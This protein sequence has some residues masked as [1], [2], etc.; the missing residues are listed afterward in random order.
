MCGICGVMRL[1]GDGAV[2]HDLVERMAG[3]MAHRGP[4]DAGAYV[5]PDCRVGMGHRRLSIVDLSAAG[6]GP[7]SNED[8]TVW[9]SYN[10]EVYN[11]EEWRGPLER[12]GH[13]YR[14]RTDTETL[15]H[16][17]EDRGPALVEALRGIFAFSL[18]DERR[19]RLVL[20]R[21]RLGVKPLYYAAVDGWLVWG[22]EIKALLAHPAVTAELDE[23]ALL[24]YLTFAAVPPP[25]TLFRGIRKLAPG[26]R[27]V[28][29]RG[30][31]IRVERWWA[32]AGHP[33]PD[34]L[35]DAGESEIVEHLR[36]L[37]V[38]AVREETMAD[39]PHGV[40]LSGGVD[41]SLVL[42]ILAEH[43]PDPVETFSV[44][45]EGQ[46]H[47]DERAHARHAAEQFGSHHHELVL[48]PERVR[49]L[50]PELVFG[51]DEP[52][53]DWVCLPLMLL[54]R[55]VKESGVTV[56]QVG[57]GSD[58]LFSGYPRYRRY[59]GLHHGLWGRYL[60]APAAL[61]RVGG[62]VA[63]L[64][65][66]PFPRLREPRDLFRRAA[67]G[68]PLFVSGAVANWYADKRR[69]LAPR[70][71]ERLDGPGSSERVAAANIAEFHRLSGSDDVAAAIA[72]QDLMV[73]LPEL[74]L[75]RVDKMTMLNSVEARVPFLDHRIVEL[76]MGLPW[77]LKLRNGT[78]KHVLK[79]AARAYLGPEIVD[80][81][82]KGFDVPLSAWLRDD[83]FGRWA[84]AAVLESRIARADVFDR[85]E[86]IRL[87]ARHRAGAGDHGFQLWTLVNLCA[88]YDHWVEPR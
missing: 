10:G 69:Q 66:A 60:R 41:S 86:L 88:W 18:W 16:L 38:G 45:F 67:S 12:A 42:A 40:L 27:L 32:P 1:G 36:T 11:H 23:D 19:E 39:V 83:A 87:F 58:E 24:Q 35:D 22:S 44:G 7:M 20:A 43:L 28:V 76:A 64:A 46:D 63:N 50:L 62:A 59:V 84:E 14:S 5:S 48:Q 29:E 61:R 51:Q 26:H 31:E 78:T 9:L 71:R 53:A 72:Y 57:E 8:G 6:H 2:T 75:M 85:G 33:L 74:L 30:G 15:I 80:R 4:D 73:R 21:D 65:L 82:K 77:A 25:A 47:F 49:E 54:A 55:H 17:Y 52:L 13:R 3:T 34:G 70:L 37:L 56:V 79:E 81:P 68:G